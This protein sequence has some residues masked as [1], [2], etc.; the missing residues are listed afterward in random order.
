[1][2]RFFTFSLLSVFLH[3]ATYNVGPGQTFESVIQVPT[4]NL[5][6]GDSVKIHYRSDPYFEKFLVHGIGSESD[7]IVIFG[8]P[9][10]CGERPVLDGNDAVTSQSFSY[11]NE[12]RQIILIGQYE[13]LLSDYI[14]IDG[15]ELRNANN[16]SGFYDDHGEYRSY[17]EN[18]CAIRPEYVNHITVRNC[19]IHSNGNGVQGG[20][21]EPISFVIEHCH[22]HD[23]GICQWESSYIHNLYLSGHPGSKAT[24]Q[25]CLIGDLISNGQQLKSRAETT[26]I[27]YNYIDGGRNSQLDLVEYEGSPVADAYV[28]G[29]IL[30][31]PEI[32]ENSRM[33]HFG[34]EQTGSFRSGTLH[35]FSNTCLIQSENAWGTRRIFEISSDLADVQANY[36]IFDISSDNEYAVWSG[37]PNITGSSNWLDE[38]ISEGEVFDDSSIGSDPGFENVWEEDYHLNEYSNCRDEVSEPMFPQDLEPVYQYIPHLDS[39][40]RTIFNGALDIGAYEWIINVSHGDINLDESVNII[41]IVILVQVILAGE[42]LSDTAFDA[43][44]VNNDNVLDILDAVLIVDIVLNPP[45]SEVGIFTGHYTYGFEVSSFLECGSSDPW[46]VH[47]YDP[48]VSDELLECIMTFYPDDWHLDYHDVFLQVQGQVTPEGEF[49]HL[50]MY[51][52]QLLVDEILECRPPQPDDCE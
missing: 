12:E 3:A 37:F 6:A 18:A 33:I 29:N 23:N 7:P 10:P 21:G 1:M 13:S 45:G 22:I 46:W 9:G 35:F 27:R 2:N 17:L 50:G 20:A 5:E 49:G 26:V 41:D 51:N 44:D 38:N 48:D 15:F 40:P 4:Y 42:I 31:K 28:Y 32:T 36:N 34:D 52:R 19:D 14:I 30:I 47:S 43:A 25:F 8:V 16:N 11:W 24:V 39:E